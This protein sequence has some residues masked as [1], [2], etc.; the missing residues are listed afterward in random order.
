VMTAVPTEMPVTMPD[1]EPIVAFVLLL[2]QVPPVE[3]LL[4]VVVCPRQTDE[5]PLIVPGIGY[6]VALTI[7]RHPDESE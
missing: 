5:V 2:L 3:G 4:S 6:T 1:D 7:A